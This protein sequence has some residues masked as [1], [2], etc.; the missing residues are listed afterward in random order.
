MKVVAKIYD[1]LTLRE[2]RQTLWLVPLVIAMAVAEVAG[3]ASVAPFL[4][5]LADPNAVNN[6]S[7]LRWLHGALG[8]ETDRQFLLAAGTAVLV[9]ILVSNG[10]L[11]AGTWALAH[12]GSMRS[13]SIARRLLVS[14]LKQP[15]TFFLERNS[16]GLANNILQE[17]TQVINGV[18]IPGLE[19]IAKAGTALAVLIML[20]V[21]EPLLAML[22]LTVLGGAYA[23]IY[24]ASKNYLE[25]IGRERVISGQERHKAASEALGA[26]KHIKLT[27]REAEMVANFSVP[28]H[29]FARFETASR[30]IVTVPRYLLEGVAFASIVG[31][32]LVLLSLGQSL[33]EMVPI[34]GVYAFAGYRLLPALQQ[35][36]RGLT[37]AGY[38]LGA[39]DTIH[40]TVREVNA[41]VEAEEFVSRNALVPLAFE[42]SLVL[43]N[44]SYR[45][46]ESCESTLKD[47]SLEIPSRTSVAFVGETG[48]GKSTLVDV[49]LGLLTPTGGVMKVDG[50]AINSSNRDRWQQLIGYVPQSIFLTDDTISRNMALGLADE[51]IDMDKVRRAAKLAQLDLFIEEELPNAYQTVVGERGVRL[52]GGQQQRLGIARALYGDPEVVVLDEATSALDS[53]T[54]R[55]VFE[56]IAAL[57]G[58][59]TIIMIAH[60]L[61]TVQACD[62]IFVMERGRIVSSGKYDEL[63]RTS[64]EFRRIAVSP[65]LSTQAIG[66]SVSGNPAGSQ[67]QEL[68]T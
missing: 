40:E 65:T 46:P 6:N 7:V 2:R 9:V 42:Q 56:S 48:A 22:A 59:K 27:G 13:H 11:A 4:S 35:M 37:R 3:I 54:E 50:S 53:A 66:P 45:Y 39:L 38:G 31:I 16:A 14:Y 21:L 18:V 51:K 57:S 67:S 58:S 1:L 60:R 23:A 33:T 55:T 36:F 64:E 19:A 62:Q 17:V 10:I 25:R 12:F 49:I 20:I 8:F 63:I 47:I 61:S 30:V 41:R 32:V 52:S 29:N 24:G 68:S 26:I 44:L 43:E 15:Y 5:L 28:S 34:L